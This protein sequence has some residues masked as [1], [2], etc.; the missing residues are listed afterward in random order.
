MRHDRIAG[1]DSGL[2]VLYE[3]A[4]NF[5]MGPPLMLRWSP[6]LAPN[7]GQTRIQSHTSTCTNMLDLHLN[8]GETSNARREESV[9]AVRGTIFL[10]ANAVWKTGPAQ[11]PVRAPSGA[12]AFSLGALNAAVNLAVWAAHAVVGRLGEVAYARLSARDAARRGWT[13]A[14]DASDTSP[15]SWLLRARGR[16]ARPPIWALVL[17]CFVLVLLPLE[18]I[19]ETGIRERRTCGPWSV[20]E[21]KGVCASKYDGHND[22]AGAVAAALVQNVDWAEGNWEVVLEGMRKAPRSDEVHAR[23]ALTE[24]RVALAADCEVTIEVCS[25]VKC[26]DFNVTRVPGAFDTVV[27]NATVVPPNAFTLGD[28]TYDLNTSVAFMFWDAGAAPVRGPSPPRRQRQRIS[29]Q[30]VEMVLNRDEVEFLLS[31][32]VKPWTLPAAPTRSRQYSLS[33]LSDGVPASD[34]ARAVSLY[35]TAQMEQPGVRRSDVAYQIDRVPALTSSDLAKALFALKAADWSKDCTG[36]VSRYTVCGSFALPRVAPFFALALVLALGWGA[37]SLWL[38]RT[39][40]PVPVDARGWRAQAHRLARG[41]YVLHGVTDDATYDA[42]M[43]EA[44]GPLQRPAPPFAYRGG[45]AAG[46]LAPD[47][48]ADGIEVG[49]PG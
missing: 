27:A 42:K 10:A 8:F 21:S 9:P 3:L 5:T 17:L 15:A 11:L 49:K 22:Y 1:V 32:P 40:E 18:L 26:G 38:H 44:T 36:S 16:A 29:V 33:C 35:R 13:A 6:L 48:S 34:F 4:Q 23:A 25:A 46:P 39:H 7:S 14:T 41:P 2:E 12:M 19:V 20:E 45:A 47:Y 43:F 37:L 24:G 30:G 31:K 28:V